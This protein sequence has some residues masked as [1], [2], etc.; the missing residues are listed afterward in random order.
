MSTLRVFAEEIEQFRLGLANA[1]RQLRSQTKLN[2]LFELAGRYFKEV[3]PIHVDP[4]SND[5]VTALAD[6]SAQTLLELSHKHPVTSGVV[7]ELKHLRD[8]VRKMEIRQVVVV[9]NVPSKLMG[10]DQRIVETLESLVPTAADSYRQALNDLAGKDRIS[11][12]GTATEL[13]EA[14]RE[15]LDNLAPDAD[16]SS[17]PN[18]KLEGDLKGPSMKQK[19]RYILSARGVSKSASAVPEDATIAVEAAF[20]SLVRSLYTR[21]SVSTHTKTNR[22]EVDRVLTWVR[23]VLQELLE[24]KS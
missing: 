24:I 6:K 10:V 5:D 22:Q 1:G 16:V 7:L 20:A 21:G 11:W 15:T 13:R 12:R 23:V 14:L 8:A 19:V 9:Q 3:R 17:Q 4:N 18:F 2:A